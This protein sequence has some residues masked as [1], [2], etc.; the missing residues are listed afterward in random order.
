MRTITFILL[1]TLGSLALHSQTQ[2]ILSYQFNNSLAESKGLGPTLISID[3]AG[4]F[5]VDTLKKGRWDD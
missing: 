4:T 3:S 5:V 2:K 1:L